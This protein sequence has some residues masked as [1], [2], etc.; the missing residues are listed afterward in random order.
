MTRGG[1]PLLPG[2][3]LA[4][5]LG[6]PLVGSARAQEGQ[7]RAHVDART[8]L[9]AWSFEAHGIRI[10]L[11]QRLPDQTRAFFLGRGFGR[12]AA[13]RI[14]ARCLFQTTVRNTFPRGGPSVAVR[15]AEWRAHTPQG[16]EPPIPKA[17]WR[18]EWQRRGVDKAARLAFQWA[19]FPSEQNFRP[20]DWNMGMTTYPLD[21]GRPLELGLVWHTDGETHR[22][23]MS[24][25]TCASDETASELLP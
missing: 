18:N 7:T 12:D 8:G 20:G 2:L 24:G 25:M 11:V 3:A 9:A 13:D 1:R 22:G 5:L 17:Q 21:P 15:L 19:L 6:M 23:R 14:A 10:E 4:A 16:L